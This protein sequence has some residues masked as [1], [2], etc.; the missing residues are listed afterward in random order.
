MQIVFNT[1]NPYKIVP[2][3]SEL[4]KNF[5]L[6]EKNPERIVSSYKGK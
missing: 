4:K 3:G 2:D 6:K 5:N 1:S